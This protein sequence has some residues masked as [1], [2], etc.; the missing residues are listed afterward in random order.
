MG[1]TKEPIRHSGEMS[2]DIY[3]KEIHDIP[4][5]TK[6][7]E[8]ELARR[9]HKGDRQALEQLVR[10]NLRF[11]VSVAKQYAGQGLGLPD[12]INEGNIGLIKAAE[13][14]DEKRGFKFISYAVWWVRQSMLQALAEQS[15]IFR[16]PLNR[17][18]TLYR[19]GKVQ[20][21]LTQTL[22]R[23]P[24]VEE[25]AERLKISRQEVRG[26]LDIA[27]VPLS[28]EES[29]SD[30]DENPLGDFLQDEDTPSTD[31]QTY[32]STLREDVERVLSSLPDR[33][34]QIIIHYFGIGQE[35][36]ET[37]EN[38]GHR[39]QLTR[40]RIRQIKEE[41]LRKLRNSP[42]GRALVSYLEA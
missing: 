35:E 24:T 20:Q 16:V 26:T 28:L 5:L 2:L 41:V 23:E 21:R 10:A 36:A 7:E 17:A 4:L 14:F 18:T 11:V 32:H 34:R 9:I 31:E 22:G 25:I 1:A 42:E 15:R 39:F 19:V 37:L 6:Q 33:E 3:L 40:E 13:R 12:L 8:W 29:Y 30:E 27:N 38:I